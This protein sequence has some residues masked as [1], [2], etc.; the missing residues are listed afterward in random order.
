MKEAGIKGIKGI[1]GIRGI[2]GIKGK[3][4][5]GRKE[6]RM[7]NKIVMVVMMVMGCNSGGVT[8]GE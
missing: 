7:K 5:F 4:E 8:G 3:E 6:G 1:R 2:R